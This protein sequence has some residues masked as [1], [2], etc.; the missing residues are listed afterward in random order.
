MPGKREDATMDNKT[1]IH[2]E[3]KDMPAREWLD[4]V[5]DRQKRRK[6]DGETMA[7]RWQRVKPTTYTR[8][9][10]DDGKDD[11]GMSDFILQLGIID[12]NYRLKLFDGGDGFT[13]FFSDG[14]SYRMG[15]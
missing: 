10:Y 14:S 8:N 6:P 13:I 2:F 7:E 11:H 4:L 9:F 5:T 3:G 1:I 15:A 12:S